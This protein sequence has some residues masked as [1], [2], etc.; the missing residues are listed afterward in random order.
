M[1]VMLTAIK[2][3]NTRK[4]LRIRGKTNKIS[5]ELNGK[6]CWGKMKNQKK[7]Q[8]EKIIIR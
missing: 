5:L 6:K 3:G 1:I 4:K 8:L 2:W 7:K